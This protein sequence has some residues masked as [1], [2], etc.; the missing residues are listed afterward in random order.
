MVQPPGTQIHTP[1]CPVPPLNAPYPEMSPP[2][3]NTTRPVQNRGPTGSNHNGPP[4]YMPPALCSEVW[5]SWRSWLPQTRPSKDWRDPPPHRDP[6]QSL[7]KRSDSPNWRAPSPN[8]PASF[9]NPS[10]PPS[11]LPLPPLTPTHI[12]KRPQ[13]PPASTPESQL[14]QELETL[15]KNTAEALWAIV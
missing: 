15:I 4:W 8:R 7:P 11:E 6:P 10:P 2:F 9:K 13:T 3:R 5:T 1:T 14:N 12:L